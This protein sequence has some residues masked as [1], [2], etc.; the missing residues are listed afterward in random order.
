MK[1]EVSE[2]LILTIENGEQLD[3]LVRDKDGKELGNTRY[4]AGVDGDPSP[5]G[6]PGGKGGTITFVLPNCG[7]AVPTEKSA[8]GQNP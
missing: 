1:T 6:E 4:V 8:D 2:A 5:S 7:D 3:V